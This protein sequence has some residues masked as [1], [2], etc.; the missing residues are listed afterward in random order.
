MRLSGSLVIKMG[1]KYQPKELYIKRP[2]Y[3]DTPTCKGNTLKVTDNKDVFRG[4]SYLA[5]NV[6]RYGGLNQYDYQKLQAILIKQFGCHISIEEA[7]LIGKSL[8]NIYEVLLS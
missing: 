5:S 8:L 1:I 7:T 3:I 6:D 2:I 4:P